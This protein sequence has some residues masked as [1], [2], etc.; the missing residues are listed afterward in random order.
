MSSNLNVSP[1]AITAVYQERNL[2][3]APSWAFNNIQPIFGGGVGNDQKKRGI[4]INVS[5]LTFATISFITLEIILFQSVTFHC[6]ILVNTS[7]WPDFTFRR[8]RAVPRDGCVSPLSSPTEPWLGWVERDC[9]QSIHCASFR[10]RRY[11]CSIFVDFPVVAISIL[12][13]SIRRSK[14]IPLETPRS[15]I[16]NGHFCFDASSTMFWTSL[17]KSLELCGVAFGFSTFTATSSFC[18]ENITSPM[19]ALL[20][21]L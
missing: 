2:S 20:T 12:H 10:E 1:K 14:K 9:S 8:L 7:C 6:Y 11:N 15:S 19:M 21:F 4:S 17:T 3:L 16:M 5:P 18:K 13:M